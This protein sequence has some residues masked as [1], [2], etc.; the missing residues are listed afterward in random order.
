MSALQAEQAG[1]AHLRFTARYLPERQAMAYGAKRPRGLDLALSIT[2]SGAV[3]DP[4]RLFDMV[5]QSR[6]AILDELASRS[7]AVG[8]SDPQIA[9]INARVIAARQRF[10]NLVVRSLQE[11]VPRALLDA[12]RQQKEE[13]ERDLAEHSAEA[14][15]ELASVSIGLEGIRHA[16]PSESVLVSFVR[17][18]R[19]P[20]PAGAQQGYP[21]QTVPSYAAFV[22]RPGSPAPAFVPLGGAATLDALVQAWRNEA[23]GRSLAAGRSLGAERAYLAAAGR[24]REAAW[25]P[26]SAFTAGATRIFIVPDGLL[27]IVSFAALPD[28]QGHYLAEGTAVIHYLS[29]ERDLVVPET[30]VVA[31]RMLLAV[32]GPAFDNK[33]TAPVRTTA[34]RRSGC[35]QGRMR[36]DDLPASLC[37]VTEIS[38]LWPTSAADAVTVLSG[39]AANETAVKQSLVG[40]RVVHLATHGFFLDTNCAPAIAGTRAV[41]G[42]VSASSKTATSLPTENP[43]LRAGLALAGANR[44][45]PAALDEDEGILTAEEI[46]GLNLQGTDWAVLSACDTGLGEIRAGEGVFGL[47]RAFQIAGARTVIMSLWSVED[48]SAAV[49]MRK[50]YEGRLQR[51]LNTAADAVHEANLA[52][53][54][55]RRANSL[56]IPILSIGRVSLP[57]APGINQFP[58]RHRFVPPRGQ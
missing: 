12:A 25:D 22:I 57:L 39:N 26:L 35:V 23:S 31:P 58:T 14:R 24:L 30:N 11:A 13:A 50:L 34:A 33:A 48:R 17:Y 8:E 18:E 38:K 20:A 9:A 49:W 52:V 40:R 53:L 1:L 6:G 5:V 51:N 4:L 3:S 46:A 55:D 36:F 47:R 28:R 56:S 29:T 43:L 19:T 54:Q 16:L 2:A 32:G 45:G 21:S 37:E 41:G 10:A 15:V 42:L 27:N 44:R 7:R